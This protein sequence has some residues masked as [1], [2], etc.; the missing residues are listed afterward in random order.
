MT[1]RR[2]HLVA[3]V[4]GA[5]LGALVAGGVGAVVWLALDGV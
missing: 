4:L 3:G 1:R 5:L 2:R